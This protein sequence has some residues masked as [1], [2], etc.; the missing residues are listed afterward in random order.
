MSIMAAVPGYGRDYRQRLEGQWGV[1]DVQDCIN[2]A[3][4]LVS[5]G[6]VDP[7]RLTISGGSAGG[8]T[9]LAALTFS[10]RFKAG[11]S[12]YGVSDL[13]ALATDTHKFESHYLDRLIGPYP[14]DKATYQARSPLFHAEQL[15]CPMI[16]FQGLQDRVVPP[17]QAEAMVSALN[18]KG[19]PGCLCLFC[20]RTTWISASRNESNRQLRVNSIFILVF[21]IFNRLM[22]C[23]VFLS[24]TFSNHS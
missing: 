21:L 4:F 1:V 22:P 5:Q 13:A 3:Q 14:A 2:A 24:K 11:A 20:G 17:N 15:S 12:Y 18:E 9:T 16:F 23:L 7:E 19:L 8:F 6:K 10:N